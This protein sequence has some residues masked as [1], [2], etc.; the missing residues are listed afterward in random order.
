MPKEKMKPDDLAIVTAF[1]SCMKGVK[2]SRETSL[3]E[4][5]RSG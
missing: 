3:R 4:S 2:I 1:K 5:T